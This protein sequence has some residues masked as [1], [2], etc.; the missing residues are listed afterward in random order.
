M[1]KD[2][3][4]E[5][6]KTHSK[7]DYRCY[8]CLAKAYTKL[9]EEHDLTSAEK[10]RQTKAF[11]SFMANAE[12]G[13][14]APE[15]ARKNQ[16]QINDMLGIKDPYKEIKQRSNQYLLDKYDYF[17]KL[18]AKSD[19]P[20]D[21]AI[22]LAISGN[23]IDYAANPDFDLEGTINKVLK[24]EF[25]INHSEELKERLSTA[26]TVLYLGDNAGEIVMDKLF[27]EHLGHPNVVY[28]VRNAPIINDVTF[29]DTKQTGLDKIVKVISN[30]YDAPST[31]LNKCSEEFMEIYNKA[32]VIISKGQGNLEGLLNV[33]NPKLFFLL[34]VKCDMIAEKFNVKRG[35]F[36]VAKR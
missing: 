33:N 23:I 22:R 15:V 19:N 29:E 5:I 9:L 18:I 2:T 1:E 28:S 11:L 27:I 30:G 31:I 16:H 24:G 7:M 3:I 12:D 36:V 4:A 6:T 14:I 17:R 25:A 8:S 35:D 13:L 21:T 26:K 32:D 20:F 34:M 10:E